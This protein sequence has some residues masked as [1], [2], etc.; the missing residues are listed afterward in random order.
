MTSNSTDVT[1]LQGRD[2]YDRDGDKV[3]TIGQVYADRAGRPTWASVSTGL[4]GMRQS[5]VPLTA[6][7]NQDDGVRIPFD[8]ATVKAAPNLDHEVDEPL[9]SDQV[10]ELYRHYRMQWDDAGTTDHAS[11][12]GAGAQHTRGSDQ[13]GTDRSMWDGE[14]QGSGERLNVEQVGLGEEN[15]SGT[16]RVEGRVRR[17]HIDAGL[18]GEEGHRRMA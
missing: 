5:L 16:E 14:Y 17:E 15:V 8:K 9:T 12:Y 11:G 18:P 10:Q 2:V 1:M 3:G 6:A 13:G 7:R 4:L